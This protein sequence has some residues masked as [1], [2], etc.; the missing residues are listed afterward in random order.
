MSWNTVHE[1]KHYNSLA[2]ITLFLA[3]SPKGEKHNSLTYGF[4][5]AATFVAENIQLRIVYMNRK[6]IIYQKEIWDTCYSIH[7][8]DLFAISLSPKNIH[9]NKY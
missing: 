5:S 3:D 8:V 2:W 1:S 7:Y 6:K 9:K 4:V